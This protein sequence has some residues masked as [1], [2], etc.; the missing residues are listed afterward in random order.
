MVPISTPPS[1][2]GPRIR[3]TRIGTS[4]GSSDGIIISLIA[5]LVSMSTA[6]PYSRLRRALHDAGD[7]LELAA[8][9]DHHRA[10]GAADR[11]HRHRAEQVRHQA[12]DE[13]GR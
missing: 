5:A 4:T 13:A 11:F 3:P 8:H 2:C 7:L 10:R 9:L 12:A 6:T 1:A